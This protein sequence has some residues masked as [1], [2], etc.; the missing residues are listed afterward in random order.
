LTAGLVAPPL[1]TPPVASEKGRAL[2]KRSR[3]IWRDDSSSCSC[4]NKEIAGTNVSAIMKNLKMDFISLA[5][6]TAT[7]STTAGNQNR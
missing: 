7:F 1:L 2:L 6:K 5:S 3:T 4:A